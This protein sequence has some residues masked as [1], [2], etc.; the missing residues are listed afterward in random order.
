MAKTYMNLDF[1]EE[2]NVAISL[3][4]NEVNEP[5]L[6]V[7]LFRFRVSMSP[8][9][10]ETVDAVVFTEVVFLT[11]LA[12]DGLFVRAKEVGH[13]LRYAVLA[14]VGHDPFQSVHLPEVPGDD[15]SDIFHRSRRLP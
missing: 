6:A 9:A 14:T 3:R 15:V 13:R 1:S 4:F 10:H 2:E 8:L 5:R 11:A 12:V 7:V